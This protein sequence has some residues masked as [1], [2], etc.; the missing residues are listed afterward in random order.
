MKGLQVI[1]PAV[2]LLAVAGCSASTR[3]HPG[4]PPIPPPEARAAPAVSADDLV[5]TLS[6]AQ[7]RQANAEGLPFSELTADQ[8][9]IVNGMWTYYAARRPS[10]I[11]G[12]TLPP[13]APVDEVRVVLVGYS[14]PRDSKDLPTVIVELRAGKQGCQS[15]VHP[16]P[17][18]AAIREAGVDLVA[19]GMVVPYT[20]EEKRAIAAGEPLPPPADD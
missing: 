16:D 17:I 1:L 20:E 10:H 19:A 14:D 11:A 18:P 9:A 8:Q 12:G 13:A 7:V 3:T 15:I 6:V 2:A 4:P 5:K